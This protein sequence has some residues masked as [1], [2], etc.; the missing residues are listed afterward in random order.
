MLRCTTHVTFWDS[1]AEELEEK[2]N[3]NLEIPKIII[4][5]SAK[6]TSWEGISITTICYIFKFLSMLT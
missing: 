3:S 5:A 1:L 4:I 6:I 2:L